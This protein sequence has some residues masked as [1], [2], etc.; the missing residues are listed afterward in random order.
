M[1]EIQ[2]PLPPQRKGPTRFWNPLAKDAEQVLEDLL[3]EDEERALQSSSTYVVL[4]SVESY[5]SK[6]KFD[7]TYQFRNYIDRYLTLEPD[8]PVQFIKKPHCI[9]GVKA[10]DDE[11]VRSPLHQFQV[12]FLLTSANDTWNWTRTWMLPTSVEVLCK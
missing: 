9:I 3:S 8:N 10:R 6:Q 1:V 2:Q 5:L 4:Q 12:V 7:Q 11:H